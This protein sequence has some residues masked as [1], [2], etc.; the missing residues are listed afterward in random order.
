MCL[1]DLGDD[2]VVEEEG[3]VGGE[4]HVAL[5]E[6]LGAERRVTGDGNVVLLG[7]LEEVGLDVVGVVLNL[8]SRRLDRGVCEHVEQERAGV[9]GDTDALCETLLL[10]ILHRLPCALK[11][12]VAVLDL[13]ALGIVVPTRGVTLLG[14]NVLERNREVDNPE[15]EVVDSPVGKLLP[16][17]GLNLIVVVER[18]PELGDNEEVLALYNALLDG[19]GDTLTGLDLV[20]V[21]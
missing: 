2:G 12:G 8:E 3:S 10:D 16:G 15:V 17:D 1:G 5:N 4:L 6:R 9:V 13:G 11:A 18:L 19:A 7:Q 21:V 14:G 20:A